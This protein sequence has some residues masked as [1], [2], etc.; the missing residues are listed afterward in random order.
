MILHDA[1]GGFIIMLMLMICFF[2]LARID[3]QKRNK[4]IDDI[5]VYYKNKN[6]DV[7]KFYDLKNKG[8]TVLNRSDF[9]YTDERQIKEWANCYNVKFI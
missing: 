9:K 7:D 1:G 2:V 6:N 4:E 8:Y 3:R 5:S